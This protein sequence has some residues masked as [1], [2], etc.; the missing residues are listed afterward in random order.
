MLRSI[1]VKWCCEY[2][3]GFKGI[4]WENLNSAN[5]DRARKGLNPYFIITENRIPIPV[6]KMIIIFCRQLI[7]S[8]R[9]NMSNN[10]QE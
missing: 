9:I 7:S 2:S 10:Q 8:Y 4:N 5:F 6:I 1:D 3:S